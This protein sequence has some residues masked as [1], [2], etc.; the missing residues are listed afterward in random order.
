MQS[1]TNITLRI[2]KKSEPIFNQ[3]SAL[4]KVIH[5]GQFAPTL[6]YLLEIGLKAYDRGYRI[7]DNELILKPQKSDVVCV[8]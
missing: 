1:K 2:T 3:V 7:L 6:L 5:H 8:E 4:A